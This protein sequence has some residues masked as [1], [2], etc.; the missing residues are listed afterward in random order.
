MAAEKKIKKVDEMSSVEKM[1]AATVTPL[2][3][4]KPKPRPGAADF[5]WQAEYP[6]EEVYVFTSSEGLTIGM[7][8]LGPK[9]KPKPGRLRR[10]HRSGGM[11]VMWYFLELVSSP[12]SLVLQEELDEDDYTALLR[13]WADFAGIELG[14]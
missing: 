11:S 3:V 7:T 6:N 1:A 10:E 9:R 14:E 13:G 2:V 12:N 8:K 5:D 4:A